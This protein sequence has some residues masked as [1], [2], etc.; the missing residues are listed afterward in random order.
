MTLADRRCVPCKGGIPPM[1]RPQAERYL[2]ET[3]LWRLDEAATR[4]TRRFAFKD[5]AAALA[6][7]DRVGALA[8]VEGHHPDIAFG[9]GYAEIVFYTHKIKG[10]HENDFVM[11]AKIDALA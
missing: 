11:A 6:F 1:P 5:F 9:W 10:L 3:P 8:E 7:A 2:A 4:I